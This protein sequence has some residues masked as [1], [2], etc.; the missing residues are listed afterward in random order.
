VYKDLE[1][2]FISAGKNTWLDEL[3]DRIV[4]EL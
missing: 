3:K 4:S 1:P 2:I